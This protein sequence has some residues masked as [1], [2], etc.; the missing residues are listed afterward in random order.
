MRGRNSGTSAGACN[1]GPRQHAAR[2]RETSELQSAVTRMSPHTPTSVRKGQQE[3]RAGSWR[4][5]RVQAWRRVTEC[6]GPP[7]PA[8]FAAGLLPLDLGLL[9][10]AHRPRLPRPL[11]DV[12][13]QPASSKIGRNM[14]EQTLMGRREDRRFTSVPSQHMR[15]RP[16]A[17]CLQY[18]SAS[19][20]A[21][22]R[23]EVA[24]T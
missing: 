22:P 24:G 5:M 18:T 17:S 23:Q 19:N 1:L 8:S 11:H 16:R 13:D 2:W 20:D 9:M 6:H 3:L 15:C 4:R 12:W 7:L 14:Q 10:P 21:E